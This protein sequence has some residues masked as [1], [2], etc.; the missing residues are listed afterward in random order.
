MRTAMIECLAVAALMAAGCVT[1]EPT[2]LDDRGQA[3][4]D[5]PPPEDLAG[6]KANMF[7]SGVSAMSSACNPL[8]GMYVPG[9]QRCIMRGFRIGFG[10]ETSASQCSADGGYWSSST[11]WFSSAWHP[12]VPVD[13][14]S[15]YKITQPG[16]WDQSPAC[17]PGP[18]ASGI[19]GLVNGSLSYDPSGCGTGTP[20]RCTYSSGRLTYR[21][22]HSYGFESSN[23][24]AI[25]GRWGDGA[26]PGLLPRC[27]AAGWLPAYAD[28]Q[29]ESAACTFW[30][31]SY[32]GTTY[33]CWHAAPWPF[34]ILSR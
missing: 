25:G 2:A 34:H 11:C 15:T 1:D 29:G 8:G 23:C 16:W 7:A 14:S 21:D 19:C 12:S 9:T 32:N 6:W 27:Y 3:L 5:E 26:P 22:A 20:Y 33:A 31:G 30:G 28:M 24:T 10:A 13:Y 17:L 18:N 4:D